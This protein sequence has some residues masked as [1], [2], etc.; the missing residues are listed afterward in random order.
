MVIPDRYLYRIGYRCPRCGE[1]HLTED[2]AQSFDGDLDLP[3]IVV[4]DSARGSYWMNP[5]MAGK[6]KSVTYFSESDAG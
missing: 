4:T 5:F 2:V 6:P 3:Y 1:P